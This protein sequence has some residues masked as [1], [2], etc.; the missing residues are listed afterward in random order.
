MPASVR[1]ALLALVSALGVVLATACGGGGGGTAGVGTYGYDGRVEVPVLPLPF[2]LPDPGPAQWTVAFP[3]LVFDRPIAVVAVPGSDDLVVAEQRGRLRRFRNDPNVT[4]AQVTTILDLDDRVLFGGEEGLL[5]VA[6]DPAYAQ[7]GWVYVYWCRDNPRRTVV[8]RFRRD[9]DDG[10][11]GKLLDEGSEQVLLSIPQPFSNHK[12]GSLQF[13]PDGKLYVSTGDGG[14]GNDPFDNAQDLGNLLG[15]ILRV[16]RDGSIPSD[17]PFA[18]AGSAVRGEIWAYGLRNPFRMSFD[19]QGRLWVGDVGQGAF[20]E[21][22]VVD[23]GQNLGWP[24]FEGERSNKNPFDLS[25]DDYTG[26]WWTYG[27]GDGVAVIGG[28]VYRGRAVPALVGAY[29]YADYGSGNVW[30]LVHDGVQALSNTPVGNLP[31]PASFGEDDDGELLACCFDGRLRQLVAQPGGGTASEMPTLLSATGAFASTVD[32]AAVPGAIEYGVNTELWS[33]GAH[34]RR[35]LVLPGAAKIEVQG[36]QAEGLIGDG[37]IVL[38]VGTAL[39]KHFEFEVAPGVVQRLE[40]RFLLHQ[41]DGWRGYTY[42]WND[43]GTDAELVPPGGEDRTFDVA[44]PSGSETRSWRYPSRG[45]C[46][47]CHTAAAGRVLGVTVPQLNR[48]F[49]YPLRTAD[50]LGTWRFLGLFVGDPGESA[51]LPRFVARDD[52]TASVDERVRCY[53][54][55]NCSFC[56]RPGGTA[57]TTMDFRRMA[58]GVDLRLFGE[59]SATAVPGGSGLRAVAGDH[60]Q[61]DAWLRIGR[62]DGFGMPPLGSFVVDQA[63]ADLFAHWIDA[64]PTLR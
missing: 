31:S 18:L 40:T 43:A 48:S 47:Q 17:N 46:L 29:V 64:G 50:Q 54:D 34:K 20:E 53:L 42:R 5:G 56:H 38:P 13:G 59:A 61:S 11:G 21:I 28:Y 62:R 58:P 27:R 22:D 25:P 7:N 57:P 60:A 4:P 37:R 39:V 55:A 30:A 26:P 23:R 52:P 19:V 36:L 35:W 9:D 45:E 3:G 12:A 41:I 15:K 16:E 2:G 8:S 49:A 14:S 44:A 33:D 63:F 51:Q 32:L 24:I 6:F 10:P 1:T